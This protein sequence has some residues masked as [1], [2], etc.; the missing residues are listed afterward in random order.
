MNDF[1]DCSLFFYVQK[2]LQLYLF[3]KRREMKSREISV[4]PSIMKVVEIYRYIEN[5]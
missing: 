3:S 1:R 5:I 4:L 2:V